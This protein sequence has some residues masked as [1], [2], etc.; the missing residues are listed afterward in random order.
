MPGG[1][2]VRAGRCECLYLLLRCVQARPAGDPAH[3]FGW[4]QWSDS[5]HILA[6]RLVALHLVHLAHLAATCAL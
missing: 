6:C 4:R 2:H 5:L 1:H 3:L